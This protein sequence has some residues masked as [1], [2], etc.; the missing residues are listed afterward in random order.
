MV[1]ENHNCQQLAAEAA[2][3]VKRPWQHYVPEVYHQFNKVFSEEQ[4]EK[5]PDNRKWDHAIDLKPDAPPHLD[6]RVYPMS[7]KEKEAQKEFIATVTP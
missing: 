4:S 2:D 5:F 1:E 6:C 3:K 7:L